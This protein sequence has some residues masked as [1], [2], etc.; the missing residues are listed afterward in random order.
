MNRLPFLVVAAALLAGAATAP[1]SAKVDPAAMAVPAKISAAFEKNDGAT[2]RTLCAADAVVIDEFPPYVW[3]GEEACVK[4]SADFVA[5]AKQIKL[6]NMHA[7]LAPKPFVDMGGGRIY[8]TTRATGTAM[9]AGKPMTEAGTWT[10]VLVKDGNAWK[11]ASLSWG[12]LH[13]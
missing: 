6:T 8:V 12:T 13:R 9:F 7:T 1:A 10:F 2:L 3:T 11:A 5:F 4:W